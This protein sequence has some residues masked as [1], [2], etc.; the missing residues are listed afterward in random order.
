MGDGIVQDLFKYNIESFS[1]AYFRTTPK[2]DVVDNNMAETFNGWILEARCKPIITMFEEIRTQVMRRLHINRRLCSTWIC[3]VGP[4]PMQKLEKNKELF[5]QWNMVWNGDDGYEVSDVYNH[6]NRHTVHLNSSRCTCRKWDLTGIPCQHAICAIYSA[7]K[8]PQDYM[9]HWYREKTYMKAYQYMMQP[10]PG[11]IL[12]TDTGKEEIVPPPYRKLPGRPKVN[13]KKD[14]D[15]TR[16][17]GKLS[18]RGKV[19]RCRIC[20]ET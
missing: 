3:D 7:E 19:M 11:K 15:E 13:R 20:K 4:R 2:C 1:K 16:K 9:S 8:E 14:K 17:I 18:K 5:Y 12:W 6:D 10:V